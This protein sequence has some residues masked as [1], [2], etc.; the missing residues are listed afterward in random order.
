MKL[1]LSGKNFVWRKGCACICCSG[2]SFC[3]FRKRIYFVHT[4]VS[5]KSILAFILF[6]T[7]AQSKYT[8]RQR[9][10]SI[11]WGEAD[12][13]MFGNTRNTKHTKIVNKYVFVSKEQHKMLLFT[14]FGHGRLQLLFC[15]VL[16]SRIAKE[17]H[18]DDGDDD[19]VNANRINEPSMRNHRLR[20]KIHWV[21]TMQINHSRRI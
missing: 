18:N 11:D 10:H 6:E 2:W 15:F 7:E 16:S 9:K 17:S 20:V 5:S 13:S 4:R 1:C 21:I 8:I 19:H 3:R 14:V 12:G